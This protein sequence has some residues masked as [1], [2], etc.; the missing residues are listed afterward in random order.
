V[1]VRMMPLHNPRGDHFGAL[2]LMTPDFSPAA[3]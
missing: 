1:T 2:L 3:P